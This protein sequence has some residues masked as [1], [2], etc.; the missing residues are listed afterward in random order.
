MITIKKSALSVLLMLL[1][2]ALIPVSGISSLL[3]KSGI[4]LSSKSDEAVKLFVQGREAF[5]MGRIA[6]ASGLM[7]RALQKDANFALV[8]LYK[9]Y[10]S[11]SDA[12]WRANMD[13]A[14]SH[15]NTA[16]EEERILINY[17]EARNDGN[18]EKCFE[19]AERLAEM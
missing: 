5:E 7:E 9:A 14:K 6:D 10:M 11:D 2:F 12:G 16:S 13:K 8:W 1:F 18:S 4:P 15:R 17:E 3:V 19:L